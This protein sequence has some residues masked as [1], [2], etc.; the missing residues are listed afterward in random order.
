MR[1]AARPAVCRWGLPALAFCISLLTAL[2]LNQPA[3]A[4]PALALN[5]TSGAPGIKVTATGT[6]FDSYKGDVLH[7]FFDSIETD[8]SPVTVPPTGIFSTVFTTPVTAIPGPHRVR[9][10]SGNITSPVLAEAAFTIDTPAITLDFPN[11]HVGTGVIISGSGFP[12]SGVVSLTYDSTGLSTEPVAGDGCFVHGMAVP[13]S[14]GGP[15]RITAT[16]QTGHYAETFFEVVASIKLNMASGAPGETLNIRGSGFGHRSSVSVLFG[17]FAAAS[18]LASDFGSF[19]TDLNIPDIEPGPYTITV[20]DNTGNQDNASFL[21]GATVKVS[22][23]TGAVGTPLTVHGGGFR[24]GGTVTVKFD[25]MA[26]GDALADLN[27]A[28]DIS[29]KVPV[30]PAG[31]H[32]ILVTDG[33]TTRKLTFSIESDAPPPPVPVSPGVM[34]PT[35]FPWNITLPFSWQA[36]EDPSQ[37][38][39]Y[40]FEIAVDESFRSPLIKKTGLAGTQYVLTENEALKAGFVPVTYFWRVMATDAAGNEGQWSPA[41]PF[42]ATAPPAPTPLEPAPGA[43]LES[44]FHFT[45]QPVSNSVPPV[46]YSL[47]AATDEEFRSLVLNETGLSDTEYVLPENSQLLRG[48]TSYFWRVRATDGA[49]NSGDW[50]KPISFTAGSSFHFPS[51]AIFSLI[52]VAAAAGIFLAYYLGKNRAANPPEELSGPGDVI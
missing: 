24:P 38:V 31:D 42:S 5:P 51:W 8:G 40:T 25:D 35:S 47:Q 17:S 10:T 39:V 14:I 22:L 20:Q 34:S 29:F 48:G 4:S 11:G 45:W 18:V 27:G 12:A 44:P 36:A 30:A 21:V 33:D 16:D 52:G 28:F 41:Q 6:V 3:L 23:G 43:R 19:N 26:A 37:P 46:V 13:E 1:T 49:G 50:S 7:I 15:H 32:D 9:V 2:A